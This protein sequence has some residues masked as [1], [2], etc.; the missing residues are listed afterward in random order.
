MIICF[1]YIIINVCLS[2]YATGHVTIPSGGSMH[3]DVYIG[4]EWSA[5]NWIWVGVIIFCSILL[6]LP[7]MYSSVD[8]KKSCK[9]SAFLPWGINVGGVLYAL[10]NLFLV[11]FISFILLERATIEFYSIY[12][13]STNEIFVNDSFIWTY[14]AFILLTIFPIYTFFTIM[15]FI[16]RMY[17]KVA[18]EKEE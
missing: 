2:I 17:F 16:Y 10:L 11:V 9:L 1:L 18:Y 14:L 6:M 13:E 8:L 12:Y 7:W 4:W 15:L 5:V 3:Y